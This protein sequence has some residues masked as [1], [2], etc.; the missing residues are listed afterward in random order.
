MGVSKM[1]P[2]RYGLAYVATAPKLVALAVFAKVELNIDTSKIR[3]KMMMS[4]HVL[5]FTSVS[6][7]IGTSCTRQRQIEIRTNSAFRIFD[8]VYL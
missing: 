6:A 7:I 2:L 1:L 3:I 5:L 4:F 8:S